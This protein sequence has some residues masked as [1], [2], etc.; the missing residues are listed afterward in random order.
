MPIPD[1]GAAI[2]ALEPHIRELAQ[3]W[4]LSLERPRPRPPV[5]DRWDEVLNEWVGSQ[6]LPLILRNGG[7]R[8]QTVRRSDGRQIVYADNT[9][10]HWALSLAQ[11]GRCVD[12][13]DLRVDDIGEKV[14]LSMVS[15]RV[16]SYQNLN[17]LGWKVCHIRPV[18]AG[19]NINYETADINVVT[20]AFLRFM[21]PRNMFV[22]PSVFG[23][24][25][26]LSQAWEAVGEHDR[27]PI[28]SLIEFCRQDGRVCPMP[29]PWDHLW[30]MLPERRRCARR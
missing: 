8:C 21:S 20:D 6:D 16:G 7:R 17:R 9:P 14:P 12:L 3:F 30:N 13:S 18:Y 1:A 27:D 26:E 25:G 28:G 23:G 4:A 29:T 5:L 15:H 22:V 11:E 10:A 19:R 24:I 2:A